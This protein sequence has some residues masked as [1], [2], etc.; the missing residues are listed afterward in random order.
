MK[1]LLIHAEYFEYSLRE[2]KSLMERYEK[3]EILLENTLVVFVTIEKGDK[4][5][6]VLSTKACKEIINLFKKVRANNIVLYPYPYLSERP[7]SIDKTIEVM[8]MIEKSIME[9]EIIVHK[10]PYRVEFSIRPHV[11]LLSEIL[12]T[13]DT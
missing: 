12:K 7:E 13:I 1:I 2:T 11:H 6:E 8:E 3:H 10:V 4:N 5:F 9:R